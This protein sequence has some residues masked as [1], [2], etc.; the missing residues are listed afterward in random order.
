VNRDG[1]QATRLTF[2]G[3]SLNPSYTPDGHIIFGRIT[4]DGSRD[5]HTMRADGSHATLIKAV[6]GIGRFPHLIEPTAKDVT[7]GLPLGEPFNVLREC[8]IA[9]PVGHPDVPTISR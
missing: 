2:D 3:R 9:P 4:D 8:V 6:D 1:S 7:K 5:H